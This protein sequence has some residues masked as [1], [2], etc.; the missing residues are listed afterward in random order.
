MEKELNLASNNQEFLK[1]PV[2]SIKQKLHP[3]LLKQM[4]TM[5]DFDLKFINQKPEVDGPILYLV[6]HSNMHDAPITCE[7][8]EEHFYILR[9]KQ[10]L[11]LLNR[12]FFAANGNIVVDRDN[13]KSGPRASAKMKK[14]L[15]AGV[16]VTIYLEKT[17]CKAPSNPINHC[18][19]GWFDIAKSTNATVVPIAL[20]YYE[21]TDN[22]CYINFG[23][24]FKVT[25]SD[26]KEVRH[27][28]L[29]EELVTLKY[30]IWEQFSIQNRSDVP[31]NLWNAIMTLR[32]RELGTTAKEME[33]ENK[34]IIGYSNSPEYV[35]GSKEFQVG[36]QKL[37]EIYGPIEGNKQFIKTK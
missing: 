26:I 10:H 34:Y 9:A 24:P 32:Y 29:E 7:I 13:K 14:L 12:V 2:V 4:T 37:D 5:R 20:E 3:L 35:F 19:W 8:V 22:C 1:H 18:Y 17:W 25:E 36:L 16:S 15:N 31:R 6:T 11:N 30:E 28:E 21:Y 27:E 23:K 33:K